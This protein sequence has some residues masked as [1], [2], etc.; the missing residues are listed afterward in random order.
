M[1]RPFSL[2]VSDSNY[3]L[4]RYMFLNVV[5]ANS[6]NMIPRNIKATTI[7]TPLY[8][9]PYRILTHYSIQIFL[10]REIHCHAYTCY[11]VDMAPDTDMLVTSLPYE[12]ANSDLISLSHSS[13]NTVSE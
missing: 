12:F 13:K 7:F 6:K 9:T 3:N 10:Q 4:T 5:A 11:R 1:Q 2:V 8:I